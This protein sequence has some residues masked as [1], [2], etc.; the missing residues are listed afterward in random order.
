[1][2]FLP[3]M[4]ALFFIVFLGVSGLVFVKLNSL[5]NR[6]GTF[7]T[8]SEIDRRFGDLEA[9]QETLAGESFKARLNIHERLAALETGVGKPVLTGPQSVEY[10]ISQLKN[11]L[12]AFNEIAEMNPDQ[13]LQLEERMNRAIDN[14]CDKH[15]EGDDVLA[16]LLV[17]LRTSKDPEWRSYLIAKV[18]WKMGLPALEALMEFFRDRDNEGRLR[19]LA[20]KAVMNFGGRAQLDEFARALADQEEPLTVRTG[21]ANLFHSHPSPAAEPG[22]IEGVRGRW[23]EEEEEYAPYAFQHRIA[24]LKAMG[25]HDSAMVVAFL[26]EFIYGAAVGDVAR[27]EDPTLVVFALRSY[28]AI[29]REKIKPFFESLLADPT[30]SEDLAEVLTNHLAIYE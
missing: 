7:P 2:K 9:R 13:G 24:C 17:S 27:R 5:E 16:E 26:E 11:D 19:N 18:I 10:L 21:L 12:L 3:T 28:A 15:E 23:N 6:I 30:L 4:V 22:L 29:Q 1:M 14:L 25:S 8:Y 20:A